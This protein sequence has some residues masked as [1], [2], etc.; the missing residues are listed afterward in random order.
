MSNQIGVI[1]VIEQTIF[2]ECRGVHSK[3]YCNKIANNILD[4]LEINGFDFIK[5]E[6]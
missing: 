2:Q 4:N 1:E 6:V 5:I 3:E